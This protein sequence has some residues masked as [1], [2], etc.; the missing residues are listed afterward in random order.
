VGVLA[1]A[2]D[3]LRATPF[4]F[5]DVGDRGLTAGTRLG[6]R[7]ISSRATDD[8][9]LLWHDPHRIHPQRLLE[10]LRF[11][12]GDVSVAGAAS[13]ANSP[14]AGTFQ[15]SGDEAGPAA[16]SGLRLGGAFRYH[17]AVSQGCRSV[18]APM[19]VTRAHDNIILEIDGRPALRV[20]RERVP[21]VFATETAEVRKTLF[22]GPAD[23]DAPL[24]SR[25]APPYRRVVAADP[26]TGILAIASD[27]QEGQYVTLAVQ[28][29][30][31][32]RSDLDR[33]IRRA[34]AESPGVSFRFGLYFNCLARG[35]NLY[36]ESAVDTSVISR[37][38]P[39]LPVLGFFGNAEIAPV[40]GTNRV[41]TN[42]G[43]L[44]LVGE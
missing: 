2:S 28:D 22:V 7:L 44:V 33:S 20:A 5:E 30:A 18:G 12:L 23:S 27:V 37:V 42:S 43:V 39:D 38:L 4:L 1:A 9:V 10:G 34:V 21:E 3:Q 6:Q 11:A 15:F 40:A 8:L 32:A 41:L 13:S 35:R 31:V 29:G 19:R 25:E 36:Q 17:A 26:D 24:D 16:V 14:D